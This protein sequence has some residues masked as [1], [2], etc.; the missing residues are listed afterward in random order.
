MKKRG[1]LFPLAALTF[2]I[3]AHLS[4]P[5]LALAQDSENAPSGEE[6]TS[7]PGAKKEE[8]PAPKEELNAAPKEEAKA[9]PKEHKEEA[10]PSSVP[11]PEQK[12]FVPPKKQR[13]A[14]LHVY[15]SKNDT[16]ITNFK[17]LTKKARR[18]ITY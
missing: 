7:A 15:S 2:F 14:I 4:Y 10:K 16:I 17:W 8:K 3:S 9:T 1:K 18:H 5:G 13:M 11:A 12:V 6:S